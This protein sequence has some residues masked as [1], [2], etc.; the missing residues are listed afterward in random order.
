MAIHIQ[1]QLFT[2]LKNPHKLKNLELIIF[3]DLQNFYEKIT[4]IIQDI[5]YFYQI[6]KLN[7]VEEFFHKFIRFLYIDDLKL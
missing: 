6:L 7:N 5:L 4:Q 2:S 1:R 3:L